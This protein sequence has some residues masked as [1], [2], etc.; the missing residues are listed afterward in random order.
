MKISEQEEAY[1]RKCYD[2]YA[3]LNSE[4][5]QNIRT[6][7]IDLRDQYV[8]RLAHLDG[9]ELIKEQGKLQAV[10]EIL[11]YRNVVLGHIEQYKQLQEHGER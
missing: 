11:N 6:M 7:L 10:S 1:Y 3:E 2:I 5:F 8:D 4:R 9:N